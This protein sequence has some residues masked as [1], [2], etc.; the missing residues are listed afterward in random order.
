MTCEKSCGV[1]V[2]TITDNQRCYLL[3]Q[4]KDGTWT[5]P[6]RLIEEGEFE[7][8]CVIKAVEEQTGLSVQWFIKGF[9]E[10]DEY[11]VSNTDRVI[12][13]V[14]FLGEVFTCDGLFSQELNIQKQK[15]LD[16]RFVRLYDA[17]KLITQ[18]K[19][20]ALLEK[21]DKRIKAEMRD[22]AFCR[23]ADRILEK[24]GRRYLDEGMQ[25][26]YPGFEC[27]PRLFVLIGEG[28]VLSLTNEQHRVVITVAVKDIDD[29]NNYSA[30]TGYYCAVADHYSEEGVSFSFGEAFCSLLD[31]PGLS[32]DLPYGDTLPTT[33]EIKRKAD[34]LIS[35]IRLY[36]PAIRAIADKRE[37]P[38]DGSQASKLYYDVFL[39]S[40]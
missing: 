3:V 31:T 5:F 32:C 16:A 6:E 1:I 20:L 10:E 2:Y 9:R 23:G 30:L 13:N 11:S 39:K 25:R 38:H 33:E 14:C 34:K 21:A 4:Q 22:I 35:I 19:H 17:K 36:E 28:I 12:Q 37:V 15:I 24:L 18:E 26:C 29:L 7:M 8:D 27:E 40:G